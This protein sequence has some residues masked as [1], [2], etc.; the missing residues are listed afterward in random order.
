MAHLR[1]FSV[2]E[3]VTAPRQALVLEAAAAGSLLPQTRDHP[4]PAPNRPAPLQTENISPDQLVQLSRRMDGNRLAAA[5]NNNKPG[6]D[7]G[8][9]S[10][11]PLRSWA[12]AV[13]GPEAPPTLLDAVKVSPQ[14]QRALH[15]RLAAPLAPGCA[16][17]HGGNASVANGPI[18]VP[19]FDSHATATHLPSVSSGE[20]WQGAAAH[21]R[22]GHQ[23]ASKG[24]RRASRRVPLQPAQRV[25]SPFGPCD[26]PAVALRFPAAKPKFAEFVALLCREV[27]SHTVTMAMLAAITTEL[28]V[29]ADAE[30]VC[31]E[32]N[33]PELQ[34]YDAIGSRR[35][36]DYFTPQG[37]DRCCG[38]QFK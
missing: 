26:D 23:H 11:K 14:K 18:N 28:A 24:P 17:S 12:A 1:S 10:R 6:V 20:P 37:I 5:A 32:R 19:H 4:A 21:T 15:E 22:T 13:S 25:A 7:N 16:F 3:Y 8:V 30:K 31:I 29:S 27:D 35:L 38:Y 33:I 36:T 9:A 34:L 2:A